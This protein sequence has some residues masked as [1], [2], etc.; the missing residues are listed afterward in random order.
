[1]S[2]NEDKAQKL[3]EIQERLAEIQKGSEKK[4]DPKPKLT[5]SEK[6]VSPVI[7]DPKNIKE[8][9]EVKPVN[10]IINPEATKKVEVKAKMMSQEEKTWKENRSREQN[11]KKLSGK[12]KLSAGKIYTAL[13]LIIT[14][15]ICFYFAYTFYIHSGNEKG[16]LIQTAIPQSISDDIG[17]TN[18]VK[19]NSNSEQYLSSS[20]QKPEEPEVLNTPKESD[21]KIAN[22]KEVVARKDVQPKTEDKVPKEITARTPE[23]IIISYVSN[24]SEE[25]AKSNVTRLKEKGFKANYYYMPDKSK[26]NPEL[27]KVYLG[28][29]KDESAAMPDFRRIV[30]LN[31]KAFILRLD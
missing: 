11:L 9:P 5:A 8:S 20:E 27:Y 29:Y 30:E 16:E 6:Q 22:K 1:M 18:S 19:E 4:A 2:E 25:L 13:S 26:S 12:K 21:V 31:D 14:L 10:R 15:S 17:S 24:S 7:N 23:G 3:K 28:P